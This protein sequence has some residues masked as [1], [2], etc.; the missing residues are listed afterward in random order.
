MINYRYKTFSIEDFEPYLNFQIVKTEVS[1]DEQG[2][3]ITKRTNYSAFK[4]C[5][6]TDF[7]KNKFERDFHTHYIAEENENLLC[8]KKSVQ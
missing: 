2:R 3:A 1:H 4:N 7:D 5:D 6:H 8:I